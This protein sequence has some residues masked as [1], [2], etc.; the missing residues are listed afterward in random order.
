MKEKYEP[1]FELT[2]EIA[3]LTVE[4]CT[5]IKQFKVTSMLSMNPQFRKN[6]RIKTI[7]SSLAIEHNSLSEDQVTAVIEGKHVIAPPKDITEVQNAYQAYDILDSINPFSIEDLLSIHKLM[8]KNLVSDAGHFRSKGVGIYKGS[9]LIHMGTRP[10]FVEH[11]IRQLFDWLKKSK[12][13]PLIKASAFHYEFEYIHPFS[14]GNGRTGRFWH[15]LILSKWEPMFAWIPIEN[16]IH[17]RQT[18][19]YKAISDSNSAGKSTTF[20]LFMLKV[21]KEVLEE[22]V[23]INV[24]INEMVLDR[25]KDNPYASA[26]EISLILGY[27]Q[28]QVERTIARLKEDGQIIRIGSNKSG[29][30]ELL[31]WK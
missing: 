17:K 27:S 16:L 21:I 28:R 1:P 11:Y 24:G 8:M 30:W 2:E 13:H 22:N 6:N 7:Y 26:K 5:L 15:T 19:Y 14:D 29:Y 4:I 18:E 12:L 20:I 25:I 9:E 3:N 31:E 10:E 23:G